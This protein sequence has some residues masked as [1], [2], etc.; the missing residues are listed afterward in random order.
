MKAWF[1]HATVVNMGPSAKSPGCNDIQSEN[2]GMAGNEK[3]S[4]LYALPDPTALKAGYKLTKKDTF[5]LTTQLM[6]LQDREK[7]VWV[8][9]TYDIVEGPRPDYVQSRFIWKSLSTTTAGVCT[10]GPNPFGPTNLTGDM[11]PMARKFSEHSLPITANLDGVILATGGHM[12]DGG[13]GIDI[14]QNDKVICTS[15]A[16]Y[17]T[18][19]NGTGGHGHKR[20]QIP[21]GNYNNNDI[22]HIA[23]QHRCTWPQ[24]IPVSKKDRMWIAANYDFDAHHG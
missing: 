22:D 20:R 6:N 8:T 21:G 15:T 3:S 14:L 2:V 18:A 19:S 23:S 9:V 17:A 11:Q 24:G 1:H 7:W 13:L 5:L 16:K 4:I 10:T 12:H